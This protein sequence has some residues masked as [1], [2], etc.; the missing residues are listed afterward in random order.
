MI[1]RKF[2]LI[3]PLL[4]LILTPFLMADTGPKPSSEFVIIYQTTPAPELTGY[5][6]YECESADCLNPLF[7]EELG[8]Q[9]FDCTQDSCS[10]MSY[11][12]AEFNYIVFEFADGAS[13][14]SNIFTKDHFDSEYEILVGENSLT[15]TE[16]G[17]SNRNSRDPL[18]AIFALL[19]LIPYCCGIPFVILIILAI[20]LIIRYLRKKREP[21][22]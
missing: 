22:E 16:T 18:I 21:S 10:S 13:L 2:R 4:L 15:I 11:G 7:L 17:G 20:V 14:T 5:A 19:E 12:Y 9:G 6:Y 3:L 1:T 8:P